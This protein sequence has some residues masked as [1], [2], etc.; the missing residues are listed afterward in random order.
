VLAKR[1]HWNGIFV[2]K[3]FCFVDGRPSI[4]CA[5]DGFSNGAGLV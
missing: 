4:A 2:G 5:D 3:T 1:C